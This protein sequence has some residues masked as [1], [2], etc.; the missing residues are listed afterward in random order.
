MFFEIY[1]GLLG[2]EVRPVRT[3]GQGTIAVSL[4]TF[5]PFTHDHRT[6]QKHAGGRLN[7]NLLGFLD[8]LIT[9]LRIVIRSATEKIKKAP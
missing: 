5:K 9:T 8:H 4:K 3:V 1:G 2:A 7:T 6:G